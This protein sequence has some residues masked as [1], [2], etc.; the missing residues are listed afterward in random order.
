[1]STIKTYCIGRSSKCDLV[2]TDPS[3]SRMHLEVVC[4]DDGF[5]LTDRNSSGGTFIWRD[6]S[7]LRI[8]QMQVSASTRVRLAKYEMQAGALA[9]LRKAKV[10]GDVGDA[11][12]PKDKLNA[13]LGLRRD[14][15]TGEVVE[16]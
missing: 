14:P 1:M 10:Q 7:W 11:P 2:L 3:I 5:Y 9:V 8:R 15:M 4:L 16:S 13:E 6:N 12:K